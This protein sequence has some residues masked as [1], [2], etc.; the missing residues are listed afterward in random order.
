MQRL[1]PLLAVVLAATLAS[2]GG[3]G[4]TTAAPTTGS[5]TVTIAGLQPGDLGDVIVTGPGGFE[6][7]VKTT[8]TLSSLKPGTYTLNNQTVVTG[9]VAYAPDNMGFT[10]TVVASKTPA[11]AYVH[12]NVESG[13]IELHVTGLPA[14]VTPNI[15]IGG[16]GH[17]TAPGPIGPLS[18]NTYSVVAHATPVGDTTFGGTPF[19]QDIFV[20]NSLTPMVVNIDYAKMTGQITVNVAA[21]PEGLAPNVTVSG[22]LGYS[23]TITTSGP[24]VLTGVPLGDYTITGPDIES[25]TTI[26]SP[27]SA[28]GNQ[29]TVESN[30]L[31]ATFN[32]AYV[33]TFERGPLCIRRP[34]GWRAG[35]RHRLIWCV[36]PPTP[37]ARHHALQ[38]L[39][40]PS[41][42]SGGIRCRYWRRQLRAQDP[43]RLHRLP[44]H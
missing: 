1:R 35:K 10:V 32:L 37:D 3:G 23:R 15:T 25:S 41:V 2:C 17:V 42:R 26:Y 13:S 24:T 27:P 29:L 7:T 4:D 8:T 22:P 38:A 21:P 18:E 12:Y 14:G 11:V 6:D 44:R 31:T 9:G 16:I 40:V 28:P 30:A 19:S 33:Q 5:L 36:V 34:S 43:Q 39:A 20:R